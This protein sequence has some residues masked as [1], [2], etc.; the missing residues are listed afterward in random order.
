M[1][2]PIPIKKI[3]LTEHPYAKHPGNHSQT[4]VSEI[5]L[6]IEKRNCANKIDAISKHLATCQ[7]ITSHQWSLKTV[8][9]ASIEIEG[10]KY[11]PLVQSRQNQNNLSDIE[12]MLFR[13]KIERLSGLEVIKEV[14]N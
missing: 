4:R 7:Q 1:E 14:K 12:K 5:K 2:P 11:V 10:L 8:S 13:K 3:S 9:G 6:K